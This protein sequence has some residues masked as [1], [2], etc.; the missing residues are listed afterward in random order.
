VRGG[1]GRGVVTDCLDGVTDCLDGVTDCLDGA[2]DLCE[3]LDSNVRSR[4][5]RGGGGE[6]GRNG[7]NQALQPCVLRILKLR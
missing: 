2:P 7:S 3:G 6:K 4:C 5:G 1:E